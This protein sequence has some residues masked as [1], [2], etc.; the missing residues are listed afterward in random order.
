MSRVFFLFAA[1]LSAGFVQPAMSATVTAFYVGGTGGVGVAI[2]GDVN[3]SGS[4]EQATN[5][6]LTINETA[7]GW[8]EF[9]SGAV[10]MHLSAN[11]KTGELKTLLRASRTGEESDGDKAPIPNV[12]STSR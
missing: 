9:G 2:P 10:S 6:I 11:P 12:L 1:I 3:F 4:Q 7:A 5:S 8:G